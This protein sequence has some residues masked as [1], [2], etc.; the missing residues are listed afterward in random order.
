MSLMDWTPFGPDAWLLRFAE[1]LGEETFRRGQALVSALERHPPEGLLEFVPSFTTILL[2]FRPGALGSDPRSRLATIGRRLEA[3]A[4]AAVAA[5]GVEPGPL[6]EIPVLY[7]G[8]DLARVAESGGLSVDEVIARHSGVIYHVYLIGFSPGFPYLGELDPKLRTPR[9]AAPRPRVPAGS[10]AIGGEHTG[11]YSV[12][13]PGGWNIVG[14]T[15]T[16]LFVPEAAMDSAAGGSGTGRVESE[17]D[18]ER[19]CFRLRAGDRVRFVPLARWPG[20]GAA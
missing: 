5:P 7:D 8:P 10:V 19:R 4:G 13:S 20:E 2:E 11:V 18:P 9:L 16:R 3:A 17:R 12:E 14:R 1:G 6:V 15:P